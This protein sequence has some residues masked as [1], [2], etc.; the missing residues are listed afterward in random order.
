MDTL[1]S[2]LIKEQKVREASDILQGA[3]E[4]FNLALI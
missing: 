4:S 2:K 1:K 3:E